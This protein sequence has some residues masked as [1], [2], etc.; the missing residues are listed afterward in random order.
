MNKANLKILAGETFTTNGKGDITGLGARELLE[1]VIQSMVT[2]EEVINGFESVSIDAPASAN[3]VRLLNDRLDSIVAGGGELYSK[4]EID[5]AHTI[6]NNLININTTAIG[7][8]SDKTHNH[9]LADLS[10]KSFNS[11]DDIPYIPSKADF[12]NKLD[13]DAVAVDSSKLGGADADTFVSKTEKGLIGGYVP[14]SDDG[15]I[16]SEYIGEEVYQNAGIVDPTDYIVDNGNGTINML[17]STVSIYSNNEYKGK[18]LQYKVPV[19]NRLPLTDLKENYV[20]VNYNAGNPE[21]RVLLNDASI[22]ESDV[23]PIATILRASTRLYI[24]PWANLSEGLPNKLHARLVKTERYKIEEGLSG[25]IG[26]SDEVLDSNGVVWLGGIRLEL[27]SFNSSDISG[28]LFDVHMHNSSG[29]WVYTGHMPKAPIALYDNKSGSLVKTPDDKYCISWFYRYVGVDRNYVTALADEH[30]FDSLE[31]ARDHELTVSKPSYINTQYVYIGR[32]ISKGDS[33]EKY[34]DRIAKVSYNT[35]PVTS[36]DALSNVQGNGQI[37][38]SGT[39]YSNFDTAFNHSKET[40]APVDAYSK[41]AADALFATKLTHSDITGNLDDT[42]KAASI[43]SVKALS[44]LVGGVDNIEDVLTSTSIIKSL[45]AN[46]G[47]VLNDKKIDKTSIVNNLSTGG[48]SSV[49]SAEQGKILDASKID[50]TSITDSLTSFNSTQVASAAAVRILKNSLDNKID[51]TSITTDFS[52][53]VDKVA[54]S[55]ETRAL[56]GLVDNVLTVKVVNAFTSES[57]VDALSSGKGKELH[58][59]YTTLNGSKADING[60]VAQDFNAKIIFA[61]ERVLVKDADIST[62]IF[63]DHLYAYQTTEPAGLVPFALNKAKT[64][65]S[66]PDGTLSST[67]LIVN[68][69]SSGLVLTDTGAGSNEGLPIIWTAEGKSSQCIIKMLSNNVGAGSNLVFS[70]NPTDAVNGAMERM[71]ITSGGALQ[72]SG[73][74]LHSNGNI[75]IAPSDDVNIRYRTATT[76]GSH[77]FEHSDGSWTNVK[78]AGFY[79]G[80]DRIKISEVANAG[81]VDVLNTAGFLTIRLNGSDGIATCVSLTQ[82]SDRR[83]KE[84]IVPYKPNSN[85]IEAVTFD[86]KEDFTGVKDN[87]GYIAQEVEKD[88][89]QYVSEDD[90]GFKSLDYTGI[91]TAKIACLESEIKKLKDRLFVI[92]SEK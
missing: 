25:S 8:K 80:L 52:G 65:L 55:E 67:G 22:N 84:N 42:N 61:N 53:G 27:P 11:L 64:I 74:L 82:T 56:K 68:A 7:T 12:D 86:F 14:V 72:I 38:I 75:L 23:I 26:S 36:H 2:P 5:A 44:L 50:K 35:S 87:I 30:L 20:V 1:I 43:E 37:H 51:K 58:D 71:R 76:I 66:N 18:L 79:T 28:V 39:E 60:D 3:T 4:T 21:Y 89:P 77:F 32:L 88:F 57:A 78:A 69:A 17:E 63:P 54:S 40:H 33:S 81:L 83:R 92:E 13:N 41:A 62:S 85:K 10:E 9:N 46:Q 47:K 45:S 19:L 31:A 91:H 16:D 48:I 34:F 59:L 29:D 70:T 90:K 15:E 49:L 6:L 24:T 73:N